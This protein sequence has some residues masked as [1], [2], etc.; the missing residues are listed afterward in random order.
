MSLVHNHTPNNL[1]YDQLKLIWLPPS[2]LQQIDL[3]YN[4]PSTQ[5][6]RNRTSVCL[7]ACLLDHVKIAFGKQNM[8]TKSVLVLSNST[9]EYIFDLCA[10]SN[11]NIQL[12]TRPVAT[13]FA[14]AQQKPG[15]WKVKPGTRGLPMLTHRKAS[16]TRL[17]EGC[18]TLNQCP[19]IYSTTLVHVCYLPK[20]LCPKIERWGTMSLHDPYS[21]L[22]QRCM[23]VLSR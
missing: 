9:T 2:A 18:F 21:R 17:V 12:G 7:E 15:R 10:R 13:N 3:C 23:L 4:C 22:Q 16:G 19:W 8:L 1:L 5:S 20:E 11:S 6:T 14:D